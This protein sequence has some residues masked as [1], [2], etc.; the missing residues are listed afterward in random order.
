MIGWDKESVGDSDADA[1]DRSI[2]PFL[3]LRPN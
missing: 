2:S 3:A 1:A